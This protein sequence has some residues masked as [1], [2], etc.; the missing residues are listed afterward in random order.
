[1]ARAARRK[2]RGPGAEKAARGTDGREYPWGNDEIAGDRVNFA[3][4][5]LKVTWANE[6]VDDGYAFTAPVGGHPAGASPFGVL[7]MAGNV[8]QWLA[9]WYD[10]GY[11]T[12]PPK[13]N[14]AGPASGESRAAHGGAWVAPSATCVR[15]TE[16]GLRPG[17]VPTGGGSDALSDPARRRASPPGIAP[18]RRHQFSSLIPARFLMRGMSFAR[19]ASKRMP[20]PSG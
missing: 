14:P 13:R 3:D 1:V 20:V 17:C 15:G 16:G 9:D 2:R 12:S 7:G 4:R 6:S 8:G 19:T 18:S 5:N 10:P 11:Y